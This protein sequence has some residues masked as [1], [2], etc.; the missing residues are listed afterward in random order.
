MCSYS[1]GIKCGIRDFIGRSEGRLEGGGRLWLPEWL[2]K[3][4]A[5]RWDRNREIFWTFAY[6]STYNHFRVSTFSLSPSTSPSW[7]LAAAEHY[8]LRSTS[9][10]W[11]G[12]RPSLNWASPTY[13]PIANLSFQ[14]KWMQLFLFWVSFGFSFSMTTLLRSTSGVWQGKRTSLNWGGLCV[15]S[16]QYNNVT[17]LATFQCYSHA[18]QLGLTQWMYSENTIL[19]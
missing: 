10:L 14:F 19:T 18:G 2:L 7:Q 16:A 12:G 15:H 1:W 17:I 13:I 3:G 9:G 8:S 6:Q 5:C 11:Q 4:G